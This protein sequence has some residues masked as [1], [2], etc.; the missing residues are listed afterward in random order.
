MLEH[1]RIQEAIKE[2]GIN[3][4]KKIMP[5][6]TMFRH[7]ERVQQDRFIQQMSEFPKLQAYLLDIQMHDEK[8]GNIG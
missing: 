1:N 3:D 5:K 8:G 4:F 6:V 2:I 7:L